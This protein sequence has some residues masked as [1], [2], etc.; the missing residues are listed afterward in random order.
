[1]SPVT[2]VTADDS[3][4]R[5]PRWPADVIEFPDSSDRAR[6]LE[7]TEKGTALQ[8]DKATSGLASPEASLKRPVRSASLL[9]VLGLSRRAA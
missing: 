2:S 9:T 7:E 3:I 1:M 5:S 8:E 6:I 4:G